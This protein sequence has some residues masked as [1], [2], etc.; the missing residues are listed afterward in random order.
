MSFGA[1][2][3]AVVVAV[4]SCSDIDSLEVRNQAV[5]EDEVVVGVSCWAELLDKSKVVVEVQN[6][7]MDGSKEQGLGLNK[8]LDMVVVVARLETGPLELWLGLVRM[9]TEY[10][11]R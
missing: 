1:E 7:G 10:K 3:V 2:A 4:C 6:K 8:A 9:A 11:V 5:A